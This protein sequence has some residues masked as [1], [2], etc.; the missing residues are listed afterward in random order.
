MLSLPCHGSAQMKDSCPEPL[1][2]FAPKSIQ[3]SAETPLDFG[4]SLSNIILQ[5]TP[6]KSPYPCDSYEQKLT[7]IKQ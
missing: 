7:L 6:S 2:R 1:W 4:S 5:F 3:I